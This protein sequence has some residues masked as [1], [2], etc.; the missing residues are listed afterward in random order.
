MSSSCN[1]SDAIV[2]PKGII[3]VIEAEADDAAWAADRKNK[4]VIFKNCAP[5]TGC[6]TEINSTQVD[7]DVNWCFY[8]DV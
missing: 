1:Y 7:I 6:I 3:T 5:F 2:L 8:A 4:Q